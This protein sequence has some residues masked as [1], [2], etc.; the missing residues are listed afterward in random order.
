MSHHPR[1][2][3]LDMQLALKAAL[4]DGCLDPARQEAVRQQSDRKSVV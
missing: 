1:F 2:T 4:N 3:D